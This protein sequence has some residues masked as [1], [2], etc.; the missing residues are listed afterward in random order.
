[1]RRAKCASVVTSGIRGG[2]VLRYVYV[3]ACAIKARRTRAYV[4]ACVCVRAR[5]C[6]CVH[7]REYERVQGGSESGVSVTQHSVRASCVRGK[8]CGTG[9][10]DSTDMGCHVR[11]AYG[12]LVW[13]VEKF[14]AVF[15]FAVL[16]RCRTLR[17]SVYRESI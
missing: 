8:L 11:R 7:I 3:Y 2:A 10:W 15:A 16:S 12:W 1:M 9:R 6:V 17:A 4:R 13:P 5:A 14:I